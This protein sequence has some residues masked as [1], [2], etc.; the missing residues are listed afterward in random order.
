MDR[1]FAQVSN[2]KRVQ[3]MNSKPQRMAGGKHCFTYESEEDQTNTL[4]TNPPLSN[5]RAA[6]ARLDEERGFN[7][8]AT[9]LPSSK[10][11]GAY[12]KPTVN[13]DLKRQGGLDQQPVAT[14]AKTQQVITEAKKKFSEQHTFKPQIKDYPL[15]VNKELSKE[16]RWKK[17]TEPKTL[18]IQKR[19]RIRAQIEIEQTQKTCPFK[20]QLP[21]SAKSAGGRTSTTGTRCGEGYDS[22][23]LPER[24]MH[25]ADLKKEKREKLKRELEQE[26]M[27]D[28][29]FRPKIQSTA[30]VNMDKLQERDPIHE[31]V[32][33]LQKQKNEKLQK[34]RI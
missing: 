34:L 19:E 25:E 4:K 17:L 18:E 21:T 7:K 33:E 15:P 6:A 24:L 32:N 5:R 1:L 20:P 3:E 31:R 16:E 14:I 27:K 8:Q 11:T 9:V 13:A 28:C 30:T 22:L 10:S 12:M 2:E 23:P 26:A 29:S